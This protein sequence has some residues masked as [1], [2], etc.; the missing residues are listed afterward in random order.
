MTAS[1]P[2]KEGE[3]YRKPDNIAVGEFFFV[4]VQGGGPVLPLMIYDKTRQCSFH[5]P[6]KMPGFDELRKVVNAEPAFQGRKTYMKASFD[7]NGDCTLYPRTAT[8]KK[9]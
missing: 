1:A 8:I 7:S 4:K 5:Y 6:P 3:G 2:A 9:W